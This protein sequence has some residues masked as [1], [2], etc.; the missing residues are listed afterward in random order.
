[1]E[2]VAA[3]ARRYHGQ[4]PMAVVSGSNHANVERTL[5]AIGVRGFL[6]VLTAD[7]GLPP[8]PSP[9]CSLEAAC[10]I[11]I[12]PIARCFEDADAVWRPPAAPACWRPISR[13]SW[14]VIDGWI[15][16]GKPRARL[17]ESFSPFINPTV[18][19]FTGLM[20]RSPQPQQWFDT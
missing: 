20:P 8:K 7:D 19:R 5:R 12:E 18:A 11:G 16:R 9:I 3:L 4:M 2:P 10:R 17:H 13:R 15:R 14:A 1:M 6:A